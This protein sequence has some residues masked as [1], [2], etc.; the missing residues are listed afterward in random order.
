MEKL[1]GS[2]LAATTVGRL[3]SKELSLRHWKRVLKS[4]E[5]EKQTDDNEI[6]PALKLS[7]DFLPF[8]LK[9]CFFLFCIVS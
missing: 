7:Y 9:Q 2:P 4:K 5:W 8:Y 1:K 6:M 3:L